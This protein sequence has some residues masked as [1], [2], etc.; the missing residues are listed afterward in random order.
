MKKNYLY[1][2]VIIALFIPGYG[3]AQAKIPASWQPGMKITANY[4]GGQS[5]YSYNLEITDSLSTFKLRT[6][7][8][9]KN[10][11]KTF[12]K[13]ELD[14]ILKFLSAQKFDRIKSEYTGFTHDKASQSIILS[15]GRESVGASQSSNQSIVESY[16]ENFAAI[17]QYLQ[18]LFDK[19]GKK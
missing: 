11:R 5:P 19:S 10:Y 17:E 16:R 1:L 4:S 8:G 7:N 15:W 12:S 9:Q 2:A 18:E 6:Q 13:E 14:N 3:V